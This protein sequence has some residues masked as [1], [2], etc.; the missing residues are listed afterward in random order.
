VREE[1]KG[2]KEGEVTEFYSNKAISK[3]IIINV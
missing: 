3:I 2:G 1:L